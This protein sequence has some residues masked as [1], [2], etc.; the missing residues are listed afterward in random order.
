MEVIE[1]DT[2]VQ[3][4]Y[5]DNRVLRIYPSPSIDNT[6]ASRRTR[7]FLEQF[8]NDAPRQQDGTI[9]LG[10]A[11]K[12]WREDPQYEL[13]YSMSMDKEAEREWNEILDIEEGMERYKRV[14][15][16]FPL[17]LPD[18]LNGVM[19]S[20]SLEGLDAMQKSIIS[21]QHYLLGLGQ[22]YH[23]TRLLGSGVYGSVFGMAT[24]T[25]EVDS[26]ILDILLE[27]PVLLERITQL[28]DYLGSLP[29]TLAVKL[30]LSGEWK[31]VLREYLISRQVASVLYPLG[32]RAVPVVYTLFRVPWSDHGLAM[33]LEEVVDYNE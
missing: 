13:K 18:Y 17:V 33:P 8:W 14:H 30:S 23:I 7:R 12:I 3:Q 11:W 28:Q 27:T 19:S 25:P 24:R 6:I 16:G 22:L 32:I 2:V 21:G 31:S 5:D 9:D 15:N 4:S 20:L 10:E 26:A 1:I 29:S